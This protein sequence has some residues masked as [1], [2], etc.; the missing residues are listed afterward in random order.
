MSRI[1]LNHNTVGKHFATVT[2]SISIDVP[3]SAVWKEISNFVGLTEWVVD[4]KKTEFL[5]KI[6]HGVGAAR[7][8]S[9]AD[10]SNVIEYAVGWQD[11]KLV[12][13]IATRGLPLDGY[14]ATL[15]ISQ[16]EKTQLSW[17][18]YLIS[19]SSDKK[20]FEE[21][22]TFIESFYANSL[23]NLKSKLEKAS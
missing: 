5:S 6:R 17:T 21:F 22:L 14:H 10:G 19:N 1:I 20:Q 16:K 9:F 15:S 18:S 4:V 2:Q 7:K 23:K 12:S 11:G 3:P 13:Y 8:I